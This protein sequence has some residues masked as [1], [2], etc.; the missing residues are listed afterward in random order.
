MWR[1][2]LDI[3]HIET[4]S[5]ISYKKEK[6]SKKKKVSPVAVGVCNDAGGEHPAQM[7]KTHSK[8]YDYG[9]YVIINGQGVN[10]S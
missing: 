3:L 9:R 1:A 5:F 7:T 8:T 10:S 6:T 2:D 4:L